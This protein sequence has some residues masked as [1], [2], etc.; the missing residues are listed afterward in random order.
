MQSAARRIGFVFSFL[1]FDFCLFMMIGFV[2]R[3]TIYDIP[4]TK[5]EKNWLCFFKSCPVDLLPC[6]SAPIRHA[7]GRPDAESSLSRRAS[8]SQPK[9]G[10]LALF[11]QTVA[12]VC[13]QKKTPYTF[14]S[15]ER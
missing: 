7:Q 12:K 15:A 9:P 6:H 14:N 4:H 8:F 1:P 3:N 11:F 5:Y 2:L 13:L 10:R